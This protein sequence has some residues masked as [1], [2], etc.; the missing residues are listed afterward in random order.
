MT[1]KRLKHPRRV[2]TMAK[3]MSVGGFYLSA[4]CQPRLGELMVTWRKH[5]E[6]TYRQVAKE[7]GVSVATWQRTEYG[8]DV[9]LSNLVKILAWAL[10]S[11]VSEL[12]GE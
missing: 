11:G 5:L 2:L 12:T 1:A 10:H 4:L 3:D 6:R 9:C 8:G 7:S